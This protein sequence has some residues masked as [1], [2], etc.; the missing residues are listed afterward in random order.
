MLGFAI[1]RQ[2]PGLTAKWQEDLGKGRVSDDLV[3]VSVTLGWL[4]SSQDPRLGEALKGVGL[5]GEFPLGPNRQQSL[6][7]TAKSSKP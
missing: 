2:L 3:Q 5:A 1:E 6:E 4:S 7:P